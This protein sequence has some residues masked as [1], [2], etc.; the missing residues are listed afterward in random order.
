MG[1]GFLG[2]PH[3]LS[4]LQYINLEGFGK[5]ALEWHAERIREGLQVS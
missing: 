2:E 4:A 3:F 1:S 5:T